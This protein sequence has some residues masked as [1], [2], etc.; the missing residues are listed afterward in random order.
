[1]SSTGSAPS[2]AAANARGANSTVTGAAET[3]TVAA[4]R[5]SA[6]SAAKATHTRTAAEAAH[7]SATT[8]GA[9]STTLR[10]SPICEQKGG[11]QCCSTKSKIRF[12][13]SSFSP[14]I[15]ASLFRVSFLY[16]SR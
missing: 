2:R 1:M 13:L 11:C 14:L 6:E 16:W 5:A 3:T 12:I 9:T 8:E 7:A 15:A 4:D 10:G